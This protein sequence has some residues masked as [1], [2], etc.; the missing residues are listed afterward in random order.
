MEDVIVK[1]DGKEVDSLSKLRYYLFQY[2]IG[3]KIKLTCIRDKKEI[4]I[5]VKLEGE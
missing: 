5:E 3:D 2:K 1:I 4:D